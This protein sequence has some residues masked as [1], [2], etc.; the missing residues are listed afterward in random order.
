MRQCNLVPFGLVAFVLCSVSFAADLC[1]ESEFVVWS[2]SI[3]K[4][5]YTACAS[6]DLSPSV[7]YIQYRASDNGKVTFIYPEKKR[8]PKGIF[9]FSYASQGATLEFDNG[10]YT[11]TLAEGVRGLP[12]FFVEKE[13]HIRSVKQCELPS[14]A[15]ILTRVQH[16]LRDAGLSE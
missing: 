8:H 14:E 11:Y 13:H 5:V 7:G 16:M 1:T 6:N 3:G 2:C 4:K 12:S 10:K 9:R 15:L